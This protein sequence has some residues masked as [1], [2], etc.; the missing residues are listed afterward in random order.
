MFELRKT[1]SYRGRLHVIVGVTPMGATPCL[2]ELEDAKSGR[3]RSVQC[4]DP[5]LIPDRE[6]SLPTDDQ[7]P[8][9]ER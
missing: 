6:G 5:E 8:E 7:S 4:D 3:V 2:V 1:I 9:P